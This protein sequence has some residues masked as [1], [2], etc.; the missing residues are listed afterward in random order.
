MA[1]VDPVVAMRVLRAA[2]TEIRQRLE[3]ATPWLVYGDDV[4]TRH[5]RQSRAS[6]ELL[7]ARFTPRLLRNVVDAI[8]R[9][10]P[11]PEPQSWLRDA[12]ETPLERVGKEWVT[13]TEALDHEQKVQGPIRKLLEDL[14]QVGPGTSRGN[15]AWLTDDTD[16]EAAASWARFVI[17]NAAPISW[18]ADGSAIQAVLPEHEKLYD[19]LMSLPRRGLRRAENAVVWVKRVLPVLRTHLAASELRAKALEGEVI[20][21]Q[22]AVERLQ[23]AEEIS[24]AHAETAGRLVGTVKAYQLA[25]ERIESS[26]R[27]AIYAELMNGTPP[28]QLGLTPAQADFLSLRDTEEVIELIAAAGREVGDVD[29][30]E[31]SV[32]QGSNERVESVAENVRS[33]IQVSL[34]PDVYPALGRSAAD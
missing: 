5:G 27:S 1:S 6:N 11:V 32:F 23:A 31:L 9:H 2:N 8:S 18:A 34:T 24:T 15:I 30:P 29:W 26:M 10:W 12:E 25:A 13:A 17:A 33:A 3:I 22:N 28:L 4:A 20:F 21:R 14:S 16:V 19:E 7:G